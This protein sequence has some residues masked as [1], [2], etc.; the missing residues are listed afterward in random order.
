MGDRTGDNNKN[1]SQPTKQ[2]ATN[3]EINPEMDI[4]DQGPPLVQPM[5]IPNKKKL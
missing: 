4:D 5:K 2:V 1:P 3:P